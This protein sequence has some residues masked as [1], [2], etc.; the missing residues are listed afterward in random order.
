VQRTLLSAPMISNS[1]ATRVIGSGCDARDAEH[2]ALLRVPAFDQRERRRQHADHAAGA[3]DA[4]RLALGRDIDHV[5]LAV[6][7]EM[8]QRRGGRRWRWRRSGR[9]PWRR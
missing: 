7:V 5:G 8:R 4:V 6:R 1:T 2:V 3:G 9:R